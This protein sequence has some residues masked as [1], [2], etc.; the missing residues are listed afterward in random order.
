MN[1]EQSNTS[2]AV[3]ESESNN[4]YPTDNSATQMLQNVTVANDQNTENISETSSATQRREERMKKFDIEF[5]TQLRLKPAKFERR[6]PRAR[7]AD[8]GVRNQ[9]STTGTRA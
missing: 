6:K 5:E 4:N 3:N 7:D 1:T 9:A 8:E 2:Q